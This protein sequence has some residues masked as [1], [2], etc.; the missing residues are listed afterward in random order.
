MRKRLLF[1]F[2]AVC[3]AVSGFA[4]EKDEYV[5]TPQGRFLI[6][7]T[8]LNANNA[9][10]DMTG[11]TAIGEGKTLA[12]LFITNVNGLAD[13]FN[14]V[15]ST[16]ATAG[17]GMYFKFEPTDANGTYVVS[18]KMKGAVLDDAK[19]RIPGDGYKKEANLVKVAGNDANVYTHPATEGEVIVNTAEALSE[20]W[21]TFNYAIQGDGTARTWFISFTA[22][23][24]TIEIADLQIAPAMQYADLRQRDAM[25]EKMNAYKNCYEWPAAVLDDLGYNEA[26]AALQA[27]GDENGQAELDELIAT[28]E[29]IV[30]EFVNA[31]MDDFLSGGT[32]SYNYLGICEDKM[33]KVSTIGIWNCLPSGRGH[34][35]VGAY[36]D[37]AHFAGNTKWNYGATE[38]PIGIYTQMKLDQ[39]VYVFGIEAKAALREDP[40]S[41]SWTINEGWDPAYG[42]AY[43]VKIVDGVAT[44]TIASVVKDLESLNFTKFL[45]T[46]K[47]EE[48]ATY[49]IGMKAY[50]KDAY[51]EPAN[52]SVVEVK[53][54]SLW[55]KTNNK[56]SKREY[57]Y[58]A[59]VLEQIKAGR[60][61]LTTAGEYLANTEYFWGKDALK[62]VVDA[63]EPVIAGYE[64]MDQDAIIATFDKDTYVKSTTEE[65]G[66]LVYQVYQE[67]VKAIIDAN[68]E[69]L[70]ENDIL[71]SIQTSID[72][73]EEVKVMR[74]YNAAT[75]KDALQ[76]AIDKAKG[77]QATMKASDYS[78]ENA[79]TIN[80]A[81]AELAE[82]VEVFKASVPASAK[83]TIV[84]I[85]FENDAVQNT[86]T[87]LYSVAGAVG[88]M[89]FS[90]W[91]TDGSGNQPFEK[92]YWANG[93][94]LWK[95]YV[96]I[97]NGTGTVIFDPTENG[98]MGTNILQ[99]AC[100]FYVQGLSGK[101]LGFYL[102][103]EVQGENGPE[104]AEIFGLFHNF[105]NGT[106]TTNTCGVDISKIWAKA[107]GSYN[108]A[109][110]SDAT[111]SLTANPL[112]KSHI[113]VI[114]D[115]GKKSM[116]CTISSINGSTTS[117]E[118]A[119]DAV[120]T[121]FILQCDYNNNDRRAWFDNLKIS[122]IAAGAYDPAGIETL[123]AAVPV[124]EG[125][126][127][128]SGQRLKTAP[129]KGI[130][131]QN[132]KKIVV[133]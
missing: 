127:T 73:A 83:T 59:D 33:Q 58:E 74:L 102:K 46:A 126:Y 57:A 25:L 80:A 26:I 61:N 3:V 40:T 42:I 109:S 18:F 69:F 124:V 94:Q 67:G 97:G 125:I 114:M 130:Y 118:V 36:P 55:A 38:D 123:K 95:G 128:L 72:A 71:A 68:K 106:T 85:D 111:D 93:E 65:A 28:A 10:Q 70:A 44:D 60:D 23:A 116:Y 37:M 86:E 82:A 6:T 17:E 79:N 51:K 91:S 7:G 14:S 48:G 11:W 88:S 50:C 103:N 120:P 131:I 29:E 22:M 2:M 13:G 100:D 47:I 90:S 119:L 41:S 122:R 16:A 112:Q 76:A 77:V 12:D 133:K 87:Q 20:N 34:W 129:T 19:I 101:S 9:F 8:N 24:T 32:K 117:E 113:E 27:I 31:N 4:L 5:Y 98:S 110:P 53:D 39:G 132:G 63:V 92:G 49:E 64:A 56:Y 104:D 89:E 84:D 21:Q 54:A 105:Y 35:S 62:A 15:M 1:A 99:V 30:N 52:G 107:G 78:E 66:L 81:N 75:G 115:Y 108:N 45:L 96:R 121:K 43:I